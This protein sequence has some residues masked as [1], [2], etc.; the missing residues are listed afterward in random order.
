MAKCEECKKEE[1]GPSER[2]CIAC[3]SEESLR[4]GDCWSCHKELSGYRGTNFCKECFATMFPR[5]MQNIRYPSLEGVNHA[6]CAKQVVVWITRAEEC[7]KST[8][9]YANDIPDL[10]MG[11]AT[12]GVAK[13]FTAKYMTF[14]PVEIV[15]PSEA[16]QLFFES[17]TI[18][19]CHSL[20]T[21]VFY[22]AILEVVGAPL[23]DLAF[24]GMVVANG[25]TY[26][27]DNPLRAV[28]STFPINGEDDILPGDWV[29]FVNRSD[30][31]SK[32]PGGAAGGWNVVCV[33]T[34]PRRYVGFGLGSKAVTSFE[35]CALLQGYHDEKP[36]KYDQVFENHSFKGIDL[37]IGGLVRMSS[38]VDRKNDVARL[39]TSKKGT[40]LDAAKLNGFLRAAIR[41]AG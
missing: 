40:R 24:G 7:H 21:A 18:C 38:K 26:A 2:R 10:K 6:E 11:L 13:G 20:M 39:D 16:I 3:I 22:R 34:G 9:F 15:S 41:R 4:S 19:E 5:M 14:T 31:K 28:T 17:R 23:F 27:S 25:L 32:H 1:V 37:D 12:N 33:G 29:Y 30:Y 35:L 8:L 36:D